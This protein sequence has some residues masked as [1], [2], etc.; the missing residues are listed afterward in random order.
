MLSRIIYEESAAFVFFQNR[1]DAYCL[2]LC[3]F[4]IFVSFAFRHWNIESETDAWGPKLYSLIS[5]PIIA[6][7]ILTL[8]AY[9]PKPNPFYSYQVWKKDKK[10]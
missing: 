10:K 2:K 8:I 9:L 6:T 7:V 5:M 3:G 1:L 4:P